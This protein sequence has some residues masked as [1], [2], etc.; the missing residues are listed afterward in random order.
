[1]YEGDVL[2]RKFVIAQRMKTLTIST[3]STMTTGARGKRSGIVTTTSLNPISI[4]A[5][6]PTKAD[7]KGAAHILG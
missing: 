2:T 3:T 6:L 7:V 1:M 5:F 4:K